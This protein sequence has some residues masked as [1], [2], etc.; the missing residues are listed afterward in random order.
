MR[1]ITLVC[2]ALLLS[3]GLFTFPGAPSAQ[4]AAAFAD[5]AVLSSGSAEFGHNS[6]VTGGFTGSNSSIQAGN[7]GRFEGI[8][9]GTTATIK[10]NVKTGGLSQLG[11][12]V[13]LPPVQ[14]FSPSASA[15]ADR[16][17][18]NNGSLTLAPGTY[19]NLTLGN[20]ANLH[21]NAGTYVFNTI[22]IN[23]NARITVNVSQGDVVVLAAGNVDFG[24]NA[25][26]VIDE[27]TAKNFYLETKGTFEASN[28]ARW[29]G[30]VYSRGGGIQLG[31][32]TQII[33]ALY[34]TS[35]IDIGNNGIIAKEVASFLLIPQ[36]EPDTTPPTIQQLPNITLPAESIFGATTTY[37][38]PTATDET[39]GPLTP[40]C[41]PASGSLFPV[42]T[43]TV[44]CVAQDAAGNTAEMTF[45]VDILPNEVAPVIATP[46][47]IVVPA[48]DENGAVVTYTLPEATDDQDGVLTPVCT[49]ESGSVFAI[50]TTTVTCVATDSFGNSATSTFMVEVEPLPSGPQPGELF[51]MASQPD[52]SFHCTGNW[53]TCY[54]DGGSMAFIDLGSGAQ[55]TN[56]SL[57]SFTIASDS[58]FWIG[59]IRCYTD[60][61]YTSLC[62]NW[63]APTL[64]NGFVNYDVAEFIE[65]SEGGHYW[66]AN[67][68]NASN[69]KNF[70]GTSP[71][72][73]NPAYYY[74]IIIDDEGGSAGAYGTETEP[75]WVLRGI[76]L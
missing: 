45:I 60:S 27:G 33:G 53:R 25:R 59:R 10:S 4:A 72:L 9:Y 15:S 14:T 74:R 31:N 54:T 17:A 49:P 51:V 11:A 21:L 3:I 7:N 19:R 63:T 8:R 48:E 65:I 57:H 24:N 70:N 67:F 20:N 47:D 36:V 55:L 22:S 69:H 66:T 23:N 28:N 6:T 35:G 12:P 32:N 50:G 37:P 16:T 68:T 26:V 1:N 73:F 2:G 61:A 64:W 39:D 29:H 71:V 13:A 40:V 5:F 44:S 34:S 75:Y 18:G 56:G 30:T 38:T 42:G 62:S 43:T 41:G 46:E 58:G 76:G 52:D